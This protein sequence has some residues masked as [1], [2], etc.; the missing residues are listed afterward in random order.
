MVQIR[1][2]RSPTYLRLNA[3]NSELLID[4]L[5]REEIGAPSLNAG[6]R[7]GRI[8]MQRCAWCSKAP[9]LNFMPIP[10]CDKP[11]WKFEDA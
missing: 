6:Q 4:G 1:R 11:G 9:H 5:C 3:P 7:R 8:C 2:A 10:L